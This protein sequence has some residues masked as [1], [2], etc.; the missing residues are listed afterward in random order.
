MAIRYHIL[1]PISPTGIIMSILTP[2]I[3]IKDIWP[4]RGPS[5]IQVIHPNGADSFEYDDSHERHDQLMNAKSFAEK[6]SKKYPGIKIID[7]TDTPVIQSTPA[8]KS[9]KP[10]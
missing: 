6:E 7:N 8:K 4:N 3:T 10:A 5:S 1:P 2:E 9:K